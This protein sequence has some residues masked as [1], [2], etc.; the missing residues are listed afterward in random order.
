MDGEF[1]SNRTYENVF[2]IFVDAAGHSA[3]VAANPRD[4]AARAFD[5]L[6][7]R[8]TG[9]LRTIA[10]RHRCAR[11]QLWRWAGDGGFLVVHDDN[12]S[13]ARDVVLEYVKSILDLDLHH[14]RD[15]FAQL[16]IAGELR[17]RVAVHRGVIHYLGEGLEG[18]IYSTDINFVAHLEKVTPPDTV[19][20]SEEVRQVAG[21]YA[22]MFEPVGRFEGRQVYV[23][24][25]G[26]K[27]GDGARAWLAARGL[28]GAVPVHGYHERPSQL[29]KV[30]LIN[31]AEY[32]V[33]DLGIALRTASNYLIT[34]ERPAYFRDA[35]VELL[36][37]G[38]RYRCVLMD[39]EAP[40]T[41][42]LAEQRGEALPEKI[43]GSLA[44]LRRFKERVGA[45]GELME[46]H[47]TPA[48]P[49]MACLAADL[50]APTGLI[51]TSPYLTA[52]P[53]TDPMDRGDM[54]HYLV[55][56]AAGRLYHNLRTLVEGFA[57]ID[58]VRVL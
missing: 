15:E 35:V 34:T 37:R 24:A 56:R 53:G 42:L 30:R 13:V 47:L 40:A 41:R 2:L 28:S 44:A 3:I 11:A 55:S 48:Y 20:V 16:D 10:E 29:E 6:H 8:L 9:R 57:T 4:R 45:D 31:A 12:E 19:A 25:P 32:E 36:R 52:L 27:P 21:K 51:L 17:I 58:T 1:R 33:I 49:G 5:L 23:Y 14:L 26:A 43:V 18:S 46:V 39:P 50:A 7:Q 22:E 38:G 54:P